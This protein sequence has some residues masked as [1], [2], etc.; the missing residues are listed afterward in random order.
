MQ[1]RWGTRAA[2]LTPTEVRLLAT[3]LERQGEAVSLRDLLAEGGES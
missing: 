2:A 1:A 3:L